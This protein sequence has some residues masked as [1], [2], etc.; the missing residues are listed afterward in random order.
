MEAPALGIEVTERTVV[1]LV[2]LPKERLLPSGRSVV[3]RVGECNEELEIRSP[4]GEM[5]VRITLSEDG[6]VVQ[7]RS[8]RL[9]LEAADSFAVQCRRLELNS[10]EGLQLS[11]NGDIEIVG[12]EMRVLTEGDVHM[13]GDIIHLSG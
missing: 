3:L 10:A 6:P 2:E 13:N 1:D 5:E 4:Q 8:A 11:S 7:L 12:R 9:E